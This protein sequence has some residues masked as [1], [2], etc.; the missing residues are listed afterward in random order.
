MRGTCFHAV[1]EGLEMKELKKKMRAEKN[2][3]TAG[4]YLFW[5]RC[6]S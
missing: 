2:G 3:V 5:M 1:I 6:F 4:Q